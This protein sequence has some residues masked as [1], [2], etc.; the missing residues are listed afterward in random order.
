MVSAL[1]TR[2]DDE[3]RNIVSSNKLL[4]QS[5]RHLELT[6]IEHDNITRKHL[7]RR[8]LHLSKEGSTLLA[9]NYTAHIRGD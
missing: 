7:N 8:G 2:A 1:L 3:D 4:K 6:F 5:C 9:Q